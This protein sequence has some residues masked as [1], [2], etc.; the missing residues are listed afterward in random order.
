[1]KPG[2]GKILVLLVADRLAVRSI[3]PEDVLK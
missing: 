1:M 2:F 3:R